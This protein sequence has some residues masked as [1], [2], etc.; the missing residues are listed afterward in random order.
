[1]FVGKPIE[2]CG[3]FDPAVMSHGEPALP[4][5]FSYEGEQLVVKAVRK[6]WRSSKE[7]RGESYLKRH[8]FEFATGDDRVAV[9]YFDRGARR[10]HPRWYLYTIEVSST[11][12]GGSECVSDARLPR[13][14]A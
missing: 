9:V 6:Q 3:G 8:W 1:M 4:E 2:P 7:D 10:G 13:Q 12:A 5:A 14:D 11:L